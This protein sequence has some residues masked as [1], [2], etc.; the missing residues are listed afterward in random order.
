M[1]KI[2]DF[3]LKG[4]FGELFL[5]MFFYSSKILFGPFS[6]PKGGLIFASECP[7]DDSI[8]QK[9]FYFKREAFFQQGVNMC[10]KWHLFCCNSTFLKEI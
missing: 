8:G 3:F 5:K 6:S 10:L 7:I 2:A 4:A 1:G 9:S